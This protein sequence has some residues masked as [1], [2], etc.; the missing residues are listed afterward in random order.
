[1]NRKNRLQLDQS[2]HILIDTVILQI[3]TQITDII[4]LIQFV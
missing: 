3:T 2:I 1:M 4:Y